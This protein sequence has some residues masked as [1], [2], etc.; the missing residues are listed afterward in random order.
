MKSAD[1]AMQINFSGKR[2]KKDYVYNKFY[3]MLRQMNRYKIW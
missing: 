3:K 1:Q 2:V